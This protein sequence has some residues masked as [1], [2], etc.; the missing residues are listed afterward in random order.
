ML[1]WSLLIRA[2]LPGALANPLLS[3][4]PGAWA[5]L[6]ASPREE[7]NATS[8][9]TVPE[10]CPSSGWAQGPGE[11]FCRIG[12]WVWLARSSGIGS[13]RFPRAPPPSS[14]QAGLS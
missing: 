11:C 3:F 8:Q 6:A 5:I 4:C 1:P 13:E 7:L 12:S 9:Q 10:R 14:P 2:A